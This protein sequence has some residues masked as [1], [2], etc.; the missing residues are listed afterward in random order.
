MCGRFA[1]FSSPGRI[2]AHFATVSE[3]DFEGSF[4]IAP[5]QTVPVIREGETGQR[6]VMFA[7]RGLIP[8]WVEDTDEM[9]QTINAKAETAAK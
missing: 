6:I 4:N 5:S 3:L 9:Q 1:L 2:R 8:S 7:S